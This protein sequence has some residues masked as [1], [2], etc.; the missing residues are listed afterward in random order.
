MSSDDPLAAKRSVTLEQIAQRAVAMDLRTGSTSLELWPEHG[1]PREV[2]PI[3]DIED[4]LNVI[5]SGKALGI[6]AESTAHQYRRRGLV[7]RPVRDAP[8]V[9]VYAA[10]IRKDPPRDRERIVELLMGLYR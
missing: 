4:W 2:I 3:H 8:P 5:G 10:W 7:Y 6:T 1:R 9:P